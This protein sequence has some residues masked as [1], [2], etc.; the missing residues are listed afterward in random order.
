MKAF[1]CALQFAAVVNVAFCQSAHITLKQ[2]STGERAFVD[3][4]G[5]EVLFHG[6]NVVVKGPP[7][8]PE[9]D[10]WDGDI[11]LS[12]KDLDD[13]ESIGLNVIRLGKK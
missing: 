9:I 11:S 10:Y 6:V 2:K 13:L 1:L 3:S 7:W 12:D 5:R 8:I 4:F